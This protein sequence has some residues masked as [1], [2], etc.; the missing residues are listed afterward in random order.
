[1][2]AAH[3]SHSANSSILK[4]EVAGSFDISQKTAILYRVLGLNPAQDIYT[5]FF[6]YS[7]QADAL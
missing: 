5:D 4:V 6:L 1:M 7:M 2:E 3:S